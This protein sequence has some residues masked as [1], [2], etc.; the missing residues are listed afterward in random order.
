MATKN[1]DLFCKCLHD[2]FNE[3]PVEKFCNLNKTQA[4]ARF[5]SVKKGSIS[6]DINL[7]LMKGTNYNGHVTIKFDINDKDSVFLQYVGTTFE[8]KTVNGKEVP[9]VEGSYDYLRHNGYLMI[10]KDLLEDKNVVECSFGS[11]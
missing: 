7:V 4:E 10:P 1:I 5:A 6:Y 9:K 2:T 3:T 11:E 8:F